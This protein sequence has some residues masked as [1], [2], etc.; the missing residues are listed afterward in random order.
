[1]S[2]YGSDEDS[3]SESDGAKVFEEFIPKKGK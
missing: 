1:M 3:D 2:A